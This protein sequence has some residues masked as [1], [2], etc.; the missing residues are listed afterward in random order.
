MSTNTD[1]VQIEQQ[2]NKMKNN[3]YNTVKTV[4]KYNRKIIKTEKGY[5]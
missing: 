1:D 2:S 3:K 4:L 5:K